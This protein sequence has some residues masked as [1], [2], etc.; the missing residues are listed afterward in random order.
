MRVERFS[1]PRNKC[2]MTILTCSH[3]RFNRRLSLRNCDCLP[4]SVLD[5]E[6]LWKFR[7]AYAL[8]TGGV[9]GIHDQIPCRRD[10]DAWLWNDSATVPQRFLTD[11]STRKNYPQLRNYVQDLI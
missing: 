5:G 4:H 2:D 7:C 9:S 8:V 11:A 6:A 10:Y 1:P 3:Y